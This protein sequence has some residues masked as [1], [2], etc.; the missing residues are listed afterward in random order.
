[1]V[2]AYLGGH[3]DQALEFDADG[4]PV[5]ETAALAEEV[6]AALVETLK[7]GGDLSEPD[8]ATRNAPSTPHEKKDNP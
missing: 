2:D 3:H 4:N 5:G 8:P 6:E 1:V 7:S